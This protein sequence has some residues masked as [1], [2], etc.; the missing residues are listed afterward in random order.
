LSMNCPDQR[1]SNGKHPSIKT[2]E[3][4]VNISSIE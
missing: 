4:Q 1:I 2:K 3:K